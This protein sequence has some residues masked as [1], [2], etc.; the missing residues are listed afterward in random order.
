[1]NNEISTIVN[2]VKESFVPV[3]QELFGDDLKAVILYG[4]AAKGTY[5][6]GVSDVNLLLLTGTTHPE[7]IMQLG[8]RAKKQIKKHRISLQFLT[9]TEFANSADVFPMEYLDIQNS[10]QLIWGQDA[11]MDIEIS[12]VNLRH[13]AEERLRGSVHALRQA[14]FASQ[15]KAKLLSEVL[16]DWFGSQAALFRALLRLAEAPTVP[17]EPRELVASLGSTFDIDPA[18]L[19]PLIKLRE[20]DKQGDATET[21][22]QVLQFLT[23]LVRKVDAM[24]VGS[25]S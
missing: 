22:V 12:P 15:G 3:V 11:V 9:T 21:A 10:H 20:G 1:M 4:S 14:L 19:Y 18:G 6:A 7:Q 23:Q 16:S 17:D 8:N 24:D 5:V 25:G 13:Q 2:D